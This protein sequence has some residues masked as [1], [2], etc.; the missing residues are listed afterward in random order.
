MAIGFG[1][2]LGGFILR[3]GG[4]NEPAD[5]RAVRAETRLTSRNTV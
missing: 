3:P 4:V 5:R 2:I 1:L